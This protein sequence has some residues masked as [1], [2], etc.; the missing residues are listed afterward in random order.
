[1]ILIVATY[2]LFWIGGIFPTIL[3]L[4]F[5]FS[6]FSLTVGYFI[7]GRSLRAF[8]YA[9]SGQLDAAEK[10]IQSIRNP[11][12]LSAKKR[13]Y[14]YLTQ[15]IIDHSKNV[16]GSAQENYRNALLEGTLQDD[17]SAIAHGGLAK[18]YHLQGDEKEAL[19]ECSRAIGWARS[20]KQKAEY[21][22]LELEIERMS[23]ET[24]KPVF[25][26]GSDVNEPI[27]Q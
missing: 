2:C 6:A 23:D 17:A 3:G 8:G 16:L 4:W 24:R 13:A 22:A 15:A 25:L 12:K 19:K 11:K 20:E 26:F 21:V 18:I 9:K 27:E 7:Y 1:M 10:M 5:Y 14:F